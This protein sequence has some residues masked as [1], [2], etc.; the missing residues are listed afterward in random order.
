LTLS[1]DLTFDYDP[2]ENPDWGFART[3]RFILRNEIAEFGLSAYSV[4]IDLS[5]K[6]EHLHLTAPNRDYPYEGLLA[7][8]RGENWK[9]LDCF[10]FGIIKEENAMNLYP[11]K[12]SAST[13]LL[14]YTYD[15][16]DKDEH[17]GL[18][19]TSY[20]LGEDEH[21]CLNLEIEID[22]F[23]KGFELILAPFVDIRHICSD[24]EPE[25]HAIKV[26]KNKNHPMVYVEKDERSLTI[27][28]SNENTQVE[29]GKAYLNWFYKLGD[30]FRTQA[31]EGIIFC[32]QSR[33]LLVPA[34]FRVKFPKDIMKIKFHALPTMRE[35]PLRIDSIQEFKDKIEL[36]SKKLS[37]LRTIIRN[38]EDHQVYNS[39][40]ARIDAF[41]RFGMKI[42]L[43]KRRE[44][45]V[46][47]AG[48][49]WFRSPWMRDIYTNL[50]QNLELL[51]ILDK[52]LEIVRDCISLGIEF[53]DDKT[54]RVHNY[55]PMLASDYEFKNGRLLPL[56]KYYF[57][58][59]PTLLFFI[60]SWEY[61]K[62]TKEK[63]LLNIVLRLIVRTF[64]TYKKAS[65]DAVNGPPVISD[66]GL[67][68][69]VP[70][71][72]WTDS[73]R[74]I[75]HRGLK[76]NNLPNRVPKEWQ[77]E[78]IEKFN[79]PEKVEREFNMP[80]FYLPE[81]NALWIKAL[82][83]AIKM[84]NMEKG[85][86]NPEF[87]EF[88]KNTLSMAKSNYLRIFWNSKKRYFYDIL[89]YD[90]SKKDESLGSPS[91]VAVAILQDFMPKEKM[92][93]MWEMIQKKLLV[94]RRIKWL[95]NYYDELYPFGVIVKESEDKIYFNDEQYHG[96]VVWPRDTPYL[97]KLLERIGRYD[98]I[99]GLLISN[100]DHQMGEGTIF[101]NHELFSLP[102]GKNP[103]PVN[104]FKENPVPV[105]NP[106]QFWSQWVD[107]YLK[108][109]I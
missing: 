13:W 23:K 19:K 40:L 61:I 48:G 11:K 103:K 93:A 91:V 4:L 42:V 33:G 105:K 58:A 106:I 95:K 89:S 7:L 82:E 68:T 38:G 94:Y 57:A 77:I 66:L 96:A 63:D 34:L 29:N 39:I 25:K 70:W 28:T 35:D 71:H 44:L 51:K 62:L 3:N 9:F 60:L 1:Y 17:Q 24:S 21:A 16:K 92:E 2:I 52:R 41:T 55:L 73:K 100:L 46:L 109:E 56:E 98:V 31:P 72:S 75:V 10:A 81:I 67:I 43:S 22:S 87:L 26:I 15:I 30:G 12:V 54:G 97:I 76:F 27:F 83:A 65:L 85:I 90:L 45:K 102:L 80:R 50:L 101:Y 84:A 59:D 99:K 88:I 53:F 14:N 5:F 78:E 108:Y 37:F 107:P 69:C 64:Q 6:S 36:E 79:D 32:G 18:L 20:W 49:W 47:E 86:M 74:L 104:E 8:T